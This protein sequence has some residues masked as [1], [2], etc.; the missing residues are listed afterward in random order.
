METERGIP[1]CLDPN[2]IHLTPTV[3]KLTGASTSENEQNEGEDEVDS[4][5]FNH[6]QSLMNNPYEKYAQ[7]PLEQLIPLILHQ[8]GPGSKFSDLTE[9]AL[10]EEINRE[11]GRSSNETHKDAEGD[12][13]MLD[14]SD[15]PPVADEGVVQPQEIEQARQASHS[16]LTQ[17]H[18]DQL[19][20]EVLHSVN[21]AL[22]ESSLSLEFV[23]LLLSSV[24]ASAAAASMSPFLK[25]T[26]P[27]GSL[28]TDKIPLKQVSNKEK[29]ITGI[30]SRG[31]KLRSLEESR[32]LL[33]KTHLELEKSLEREHNYWSTIS[34]HITNQDVIFKMKDR[35]TGKRSLG[36]KYGYEDSGSCYKLDKGIAVLRHN[37]ELNKLELVS[38]AD[39]QSEKDIHINKK[40]NEM[41]VR[42]RIFTKIEEEDDYILSGESSLNKWLLPSSDSGDGDDIRLEISKLKFFIFEQELMYQLKRECDHL[43]PYGVSIENENKIV[44]EFPTE[45]IELETL[46]LDYD[47][48][49]NHEQDAPKTNDRRANLILIVLRMLLVV[50]YKKQLSHRLRQPLLTRTQ[51]ASAKQRKTGNSKESPDKEVLLMRPIVGKIRHQN[52][53]NLL[54]KVIKDYVLDVVN[55]STMKKLRVETQVSD[56]QKS[57]LKDEHIFKLDKEISL[58]D[59]ILKM[60]RTELLVELDGKGKIA[61][62]LQSTN[63]CNALIKVKYADASEKAIFD[64]KFTEFKELEEFLHFIVSEYVV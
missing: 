13:E 16:A 62:E 21:M 58:F 44:M 32:N 7:M 11:E 28:N 8:R 35:H 12:V 25:K 54:K 38:L 55:G 52:Y 47:T 3:P 51:P 24:R 18:F 49:M 19:K 30:V 1:L 23:S 40:N 63:Y 6:N 50:M 57:S 48:I 46:P 61:L 59:R 4:S 20:K 26:V 33:K 36:I 14:N 43:I 9:E 60:P 37:A 2:L 42:V 5:N 29:M 45:K 22:N 10:V 17:E 39:G 41:F 27:Q 53:L 56:R 31:W 64:T 34:Q 15:Q